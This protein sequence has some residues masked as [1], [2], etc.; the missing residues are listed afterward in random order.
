MKKI[1]L[2]GSTGSI[3]KQVLNVVRNNPDKFSVASLAAGNNLTLFTE[4]VKEFKP[5][6]ATAIKCPNEKLPDGTEYCF[7]ETAF[8]DAIISEADVVVVALVGFSGIIAVKEAIDKGLNI[9]LAN[10]ESIVAGGELI[11]PAVKKSGIT[12]APID[13]EHS[14]VWQALGFNFDTPF[15]KIILTAS[16]G[17]LRDYDAERLKTVTFKEAL[18]HPN[19]SM[20]SKI[21]VDCAT[22][23][24]KGLEVIEAKW[25]YNTSF[26]KI[27]VVI[28]RESI[29]HSMVEFNDNAIIAQLGYPSMETPISLALSYPER[30]KG[31]VESVDF[32]SL[33]KLSFEAPD[34]KRFPCFSLAVEAGKK[35][36]LYPAVLIG[37]DDAAVKLFSE[38]KIG[39]CDIYTAISG[40]LDKFSGGKINSFDDITEAAEFARRY[41][42]SKFGV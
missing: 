4:Q 32:V 22:L 39:Y 24:N 18:S 23:I 14:A 13:S 33:K 26:D 25:L 36:G 27:D 35:G 21:T 17:A 41:V 42:E 20:G 28:H 16:G 3:G 30:L 10:K 15:K 7:G 1:A 31:D 5:L 12:L 11:M 19:W 9:A 2:I 34:V 8:K 29:I 37:A 40:A 38:G 6:V